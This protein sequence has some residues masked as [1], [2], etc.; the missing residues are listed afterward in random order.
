MF[1]F[2]VVQVCDCPLATVFFRAYA[3]LAFQSRSKEVV[4]IS[5]RWVLSHA[6]ARPFLSQMPFP[7]LST[8]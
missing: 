5:G 6:E 2:M 3:L 7:R 4:A 8:F 1:A